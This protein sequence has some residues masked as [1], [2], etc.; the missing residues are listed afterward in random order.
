MFWGC[1]HD[2]TKSVYESSIDDLMRYILFNLV[3]PSN[4]R[5]GVQT[6]P[7]WPLAMSVEGVY[8]IPDI[9]VVDRKRNE[10]T[11]VIIQEDKTIKNP[12]DPFAQVMAEAIAAF[13]LEQEKRRSSGQLLASFPLLLGVCKGF[14]FSFLCVTLPATLAVDV[15][16]GHIVL[17]DK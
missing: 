17:S 13:Q 7:H 3:I 4:G 15:K 14:H 6:N 10:E 5:F 8:A 1:Y 16:F 11:V 2:F 9:I 12:T